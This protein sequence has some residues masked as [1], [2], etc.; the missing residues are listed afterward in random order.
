MSMN[1][2]G[3]IVG[4]VIFAS[5]YVMFAATQPVINSIIT[6]AHTQ[7]IDPNAWTITDF[8]QLMYNY[9]V[10][11]S[12]GAGLLYIIYSNFIVEADSRYSY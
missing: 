2:M 7:T 3:W 1:I 11:I 6:W 4:I 8:V 9:A 10:V 5:T 12:A